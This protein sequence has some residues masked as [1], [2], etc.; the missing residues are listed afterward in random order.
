MVTTVVVG[1]LPTPSNTASTSGGLP[2]AF[3]TAL[4]LT[5]SV[6]LSRPVS[7][8]EIVAAE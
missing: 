6:P 5:A 8:R 1:A 7:S 4:I 3:A 2:T